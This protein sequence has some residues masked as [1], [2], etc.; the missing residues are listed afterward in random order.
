MRSPSRSRLLTSAVPRARTPGRYRYSNLGYLVLAYAIE[1]RTGRQLPELVRAKVLEPLGMTGTAHES[2]VLTHPQGVRIDTGCPVA[3]RTLLPGAGGYYGPADDLA[4]WA[5][6][7]LD[8]PDPLRPAVERAT[9]PRLAVPSLAGVPETWTT[10]ARRG[11]RQLGLAW[12]IERN[13]LI[14]HTGGTNGYTAFCSANRRTGTTVSALLA[15]GIGAL[16]DSPR[17]LP[18]LIRLIRLRET[19]KRLAST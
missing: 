2:E 1:Q 16:P 8:P 12:R 10:P 11:A 18:H 6:A 15:A 3:E 13:G 4:R 19:L 17:S 14:W 5:R 7:L 9:H